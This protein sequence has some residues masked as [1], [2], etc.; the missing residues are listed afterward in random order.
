M[1]YVG[2]QALHASAH[3]VHDPLTVLASVGI[4]IVTSGLALWLAM[5]RPLHSLAVSATALG[6]AISGMHYT[7]MAGLTVYPHATTPT[8]APVLSTDLLAIVVALVAFLVSGGF[9]LI[10]LPDRGTQDAAPPLAPVKSAEVP[11]APSKAEGA[12]DPIFETHIAV[13]RDGGTYYVPIDDIVAVQANAHYTYVFDGT[14]RHF[15]PS[16]IGEIEHRLDPKRFVRVHRSHIV[17]V[18]R[19]ATMKRAGDNGVIELEARNRYIVP[20][21]RGRMGLIKSR[22]AALPRLSVRSA[23]GQQL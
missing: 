7:A 19:I 1:H 5:R 9:L 11:D 6:L 8:P 12:C 18:D 14:T 2:M 22:L 15:C 10:L 21:S 13:V 3:M 23:T 20:I 16:S 4:A 17:N